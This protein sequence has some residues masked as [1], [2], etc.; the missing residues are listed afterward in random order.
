M[1]IIQ[2]LSLEAEN[3]LR[4]TL[5]LPDVG[6]GWISETELYNALKRD[7]NFTDVIQHATPTWLGRQHF[8]VYLPEYKIA[9][10][11]HGKQHFEPVDFFGG[12]DAFKKNVERD[13]R[14]IKL[15]EENNVKLF[16]IKEGYDYNQLKSSIN[17]V[18]EKRKTRYSL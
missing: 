15:A 11:Y 10:E 16:V 13:V 5:D 12:E 8:D 14:K 9:V 3:N 2:S 7:F 18:I 17:N 4:R 1:K 6:A